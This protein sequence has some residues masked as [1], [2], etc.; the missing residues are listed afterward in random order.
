MATLPGTITWPVS[1]RMLT[2]VAF[3]QISTS[4]HFQAYRDGGFCELTQTTAKEI[5]NDTDFPIVFQNE[6][7]DRDGGHSDVEQTSRYVAHTSGNYWVSGVVGF[8]VNPTGYRAA[9]IMKNGGQALTTAIRPAASGWAT[10][11]PVGSRLIYLAANDWVEIYARQNSGATL[12]TT[13]TDG[14]SGMSVVFWGA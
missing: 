12:N 10:F 9:K 11:V 13:V 6:E 4:L 5:P 1:S 7:T 3:N 14:G 8:E 2:S